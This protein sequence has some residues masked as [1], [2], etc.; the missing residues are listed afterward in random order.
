M[1]AA[2]VALADALE[3]LRRARVVN[4]SMRRQLDAA[5]AAMGEQYQ[6]D[7]AIRALAI[8]IA[9]FVGMRDA[10]ASDDPALVA[11]ER[12]MKTLSRAVT[13]AEADKA[14]GAILRRI[15]ADKG[16]PTN[17]I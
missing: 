14:T 12:R 10:A 13:E 4:A 16:T 11:S 2:T 6:S 7:A 15:R 1:S 17:G 9:R 8:E 5:E 3:A